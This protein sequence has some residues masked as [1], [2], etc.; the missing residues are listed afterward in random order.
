M[1]YPYDPHLRVAHVFSPREKS[2][3]IRVDSQMLTPEGLAR[4]Q[5]EVTGLYG[6]HRTDAERFFEKG[7]F[8]DEDERTAFF[9]FVHDWVHGPDSRLDPDI[10]ARLERHFP[11]SAEAARLHLLEY[12]DAARKLN[13]F[14]QHYRQTSAASSPEEPLVS[15]LLS[16]LDPQGARNR[17]FRTYFRSIRGVRPADFPRLPSTRGRRV[18]DRLSD[19]CNALD[20][21]KKEGGF[22]SLA[23]A[24]APGKTRTR[25]QIRLPA[26]AS[27]RHVTG[28]RNLVAR[29]LQL[30]GYPAV[31][32]K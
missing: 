32:E 8:S 7:R 30:K 9:R 16:F 28:L 29:F 23:V 26:D 17:V 24:R 22:R 6:K 19:L 3:E 25:F 11:T 31:L 13:L 21:L 27:E 4:R 15:D 1:P 18:N 5:D 2:I 12:A 20:G 14:S 10:V